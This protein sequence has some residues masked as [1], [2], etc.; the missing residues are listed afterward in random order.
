MSK[1]L[2]LISAYYFAF[3]MAIALVFSSCTSETLQSKSKDQAYGS[4]GTVAV[5]CDQQLWD[6]AAGD[7]LRYYFESA[8]PILPQ[9]EPVFDLLHKTAIQLVEKPVAKELRTYLIYVDMSDTSSRVTKMAIQDI[10]LNAINENLREKPYD[11]R[12]GSDKWA[13]GQLL[14]YVMARKHEGLTEAVRKYFPMF[15]KRIFENEQQTLE[16]NLYG[17][18]FNSELEEKIKS[19]FGMHIKIPKDYVL[20][21]DK[22]DFVWLR[23]EREKSSSSLIFSKTA[24]QSTDQFNRDQLVG[25]QNR[26]TFPN[27]TSMSEGS[28][29]LIDSIN[30]PLLY[31][32]LDDQPNYGIEMRGIWQMENDFKGGPF[33]TRVYQD[34]SQKNLVFASGFVFAPG[35]KKRNL[36]RELSHIIASIT[37]D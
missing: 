13:N 6:G 27:V 30:L 12:I 10:G 28:G 14:I 20:A 7:S 3:A 1:N 17:G 23:M 33:V 8:Y 19:K 37:F 25:W 24:Y 11:V 4:L 18:F 21:M 26:L 16:A 5:L 32:K 31:Y 9:P 34:P 35:E 36:M 15:Q 22:D 29:M 2:N